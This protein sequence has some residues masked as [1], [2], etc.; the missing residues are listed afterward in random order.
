MWNVP[1]PLFKEVAKGRMA[2]DLLQEKKNTHPS[3]EKAKGTGKPV[4][5]NTRIASAR[6]HG[7]EGHRP[8][9][10]KKRFSWKRSSKVPRDFP[11]S[12]EERSTIRGNAEK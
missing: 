7:Q 10:S 11:P 8:S 6:G 4:F 2:G 3:L 12:N 9:L 1:T 5:T